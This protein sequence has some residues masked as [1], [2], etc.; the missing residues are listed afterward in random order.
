VP[1]LQGRR[2]LAVD[3]ETTGF[4]PTFGHRVVEVATAAIEDGALGETWA[5]LV[6]PG[7]TVPPDATAVHGIR[8]QDLAGAP[9]PRVVA[10][11]VRRRCADLSLVF[12]NAAFDL[13]FLALLL[14]EGGQAPLLNPIVDTLGLARGLGLGEGHALDQ[15]AARFGLTPASTH[16]AR[17][18]AITTARLF[19]IL[20][21][22]WE[23]RGVRS[24]AE[25]AALSQDLLRAA[26]RAG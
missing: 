16:R 24:L 17:E 7:R 20:A 10:V 13:P 18:D 14:R 6:K 1:I 25:L 23:E 21:S 19:V 15:L 2:A 5:S 22:R 3:T 8:D 11:E 26:R 9:E 12:H 4:E